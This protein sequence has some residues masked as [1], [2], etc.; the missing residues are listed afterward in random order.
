PLINAV[1]L[2]EEQAAPELS[3]A[4]LEAW[5]Q[6]LKVLALRFRETLTEW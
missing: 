5:R 3:S 4:E 2:D 1:N 6:Q